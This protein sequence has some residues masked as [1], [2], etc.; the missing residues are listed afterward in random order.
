M[1]VTCVNQF[2]ME[3][4]GSKEEVKVLDED[5][6]MLAQYELTGQETWC[7]GSPKRRSRD[8]VAGVVNQRVPNAY[9]CAQRG[10]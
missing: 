9:R 2:S 10:S 7:K 4:D 8:A 6:P 1:L 3:R 5:E